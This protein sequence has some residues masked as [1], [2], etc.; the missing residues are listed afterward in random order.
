MACEAVTVIRPGVIEV[1][2]GATATYGTTL[3]DQA[4]NPIQAALDTLTL[5]LKDL[6]TGEI[7]NGR[8]NQ[9]VL[10]VNGVTINAGELQW[11]IAPEDSVVPPSLAA[12]I[13]PGGA[14]RTIVRFEWTWNTGSRRSWHELILRIRRPLAG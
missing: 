13:K 1:R 8:D 3:L 5:T 6:V 10:N 2:E 14:S 11:Q 12:K 7:I 9:N 4:C